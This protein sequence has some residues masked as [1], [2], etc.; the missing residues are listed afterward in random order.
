ILTVPTMNIICNVLDPLTRRPYTRDPR[1]IA[2]KAENYLKTT[3]IADISYWG[4]ELEFYVFDDVRYDQSARC[5]YYYIDSNEGV[6]NP[7]RKEAPTPGYKR[8]H[9]EAYSPVPPADQLQDIRSEMILKL[10]EIGIPVEVHPHEVATAG[11]G[12][13]DMRFTSLTRMADNVMS[14]KYIL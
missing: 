2:Q 11:Q 6:W 9:K 14:Y 12:E 7:G 8:R 1:H 5:G 10:E 4:P 13:I 3:G